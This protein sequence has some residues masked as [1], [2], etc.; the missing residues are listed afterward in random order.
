M[1]STP[2]GLADV[3]ELASTGKPRKANVKKL[4]EYLF[5]IHNFFTLSLNN[6]PTLNV[7]LMRPSR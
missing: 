3:S 2:R 1:M 5:F 7:K 4:I 6:S